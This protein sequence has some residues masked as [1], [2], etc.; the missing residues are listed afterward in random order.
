MGTVELALNYTPGCLTV[1]L[2]RA[3]TIAGKRSQ[4]SY[5]KVFLIEDNN[6]CLWDERQKVIF[7]RDH[8]M[9]KVFNKNLNPEFNEKFTFKMLF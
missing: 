2:F 7:E 3:K 6:N 1:D 5:A 9:T 4:D 8:E